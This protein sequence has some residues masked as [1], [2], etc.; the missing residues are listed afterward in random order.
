MKLFMGSTM[1]MVDFCITL[2][3]RCGPYM[4][5]RSSPWAENL[6]LP[7]LGRTLRTR[8]TL[9]VDYSDF[10]EHDELFHSYLFGLTIIILVGY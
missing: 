6:V 2:V 3:P 7:E 8:T 10:R 1:L 5:N 9:S 4:H